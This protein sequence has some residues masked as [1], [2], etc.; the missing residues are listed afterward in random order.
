[1]IMGA[2]CVSFLASSYRVRVYTGSPL[3]AGTSANVH[4]TI[5]ARSGKCGPV[6]ITP[7]NGYYRNRQV[8]YLIL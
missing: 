8:P 6:K 1:M 2:F 7:K 5:Y 3:G 4:I